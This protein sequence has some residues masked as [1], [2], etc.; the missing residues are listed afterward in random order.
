MRSLGL[1]LMG[2]GVPTAVWGQDHSWGVQWDASPIWWPVGAV[3][4][5]LILLVLLGWVLLNLLPVI[6]VIVATLLGVRW[7]M[8]TDRPPGLDPAMALLRERY[9]RGEI[10]KQEFE[11]RKRDLEGPR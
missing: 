1:A 9:A 4:A 7:L 3:A 6:F 2:L 11:A 10:D 8:G 5:A